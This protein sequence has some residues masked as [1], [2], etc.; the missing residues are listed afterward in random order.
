MPVVWLTLFAASNLRSRR[1]PSPL[2]G[3]QA[4]TLGIITLAWV[5]FIR[6]AEG[7]SRVVVT[8]S[9]ITSNN[10]RLG[11]TTMEFSDII[12]IEK[13]GGKVSGL[14]LYNAQRERIIIS[15]RV[16]NFDQLQDLIKRKRPDLRITR[17][18]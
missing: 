6:W 3:G 5:L 13:W 4:A 18:V 10:G 16:S 17:D 2:T 14:F 8:D 12:A 11:R 1:H 7:N 15:D 9:S